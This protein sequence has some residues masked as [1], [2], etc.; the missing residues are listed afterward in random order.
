MAQLPQFQNDDMAFQQ[1]QNKWASQLNP[2]L[3]NLLVNGRLIRNQELSTGANVVNHKLGRDLVGW[4]VTRLRDSAV[5]IYDT[6]DSNQMSNLTLN[7]V[8]SA[9]VTVDLWVF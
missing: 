2:V 3:A 9:P 1:M 4:F 8:S 5:S 7:L 6:Q